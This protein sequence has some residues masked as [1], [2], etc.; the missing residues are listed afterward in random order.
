M[1]YLPPEFTAPETLEEWGSI[2]V[3]HFD[4][5]WHSKAQ[6]QK[7]HTISAVTRIAFYPQARIRERDLAY[8][9]AYAI[10]NRLA[11]Y[12]WGHRNFSFPIEMKIA[13]AVA[14]RFKGFL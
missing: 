1:E 14:R 6:V 13:D 2:H 8:K 10:M 5:P 3:F 7:L 11:R 4:P 9:F 12:R